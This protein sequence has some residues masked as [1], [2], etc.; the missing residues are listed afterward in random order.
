V[1]IRRGK[2]SGSFLPTLKK[3]RTGLRQLDVVFA[4]LWRPT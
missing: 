4:P 2:Q 3:Y 1:Y